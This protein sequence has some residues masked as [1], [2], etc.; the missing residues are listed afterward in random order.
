MNRRQLRSSAARANA[1]VRSSSSRS[2]PT[3]GGEERARRLSDLRDDL[4][5]PVGGDGLGL[6]LQ[7]ERLDR[8]GVDRVADQALGGVADQ[9]LAGL[10]GGLQAGGGVHRVAGHAA[11]VRGLGADEHLAGVHADPAGESDAVVAFELVVEV[12]ERG[13]H[14]GGGADGAQRVVLVELRDAEDGHHRVAD[15][16]LDRAAVAFERRTHRVEVAR[17]DLA[18]RLGVEP[19]AQLG[20]A[21]HVAE[22]D[23]DGLADL[24]RLASAAPKRVPQTEQKFAPSAFS[25]PQFGQAVTAGV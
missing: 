16:L 25:E 19:L 7:R 14:V 22:D 15:E 10:G 1:R 24:G 13:A 3:I 18:H 8:L 20:R 12:L 17:H 21:R 11:D 9:D 6:A 23:R 4:D 5:Q 2:R